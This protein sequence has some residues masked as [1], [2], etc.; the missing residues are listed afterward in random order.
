MNAVNKI[1]K[2]STVL[3]FAVLYDTVLYFSG[4]TV[5]YYRGNIV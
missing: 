2:Y 1:S 5:L 4:N 3:C